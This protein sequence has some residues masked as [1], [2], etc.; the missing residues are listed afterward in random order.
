MRIVSFSDIHGNFKVFEKCR[1]LLLGADIVILSGDITDF[2]NHRDSSRG[3]RELKKIFDKEIFAVT[4]NCDL[5]SAETSLNNLGINISERVI[6]KKGFLFAGIKGSLVTP[7]ST[8]NEFLESDYEK[9]LL[10]IE[11]NLKKEIPFVFVTH[12]PPFDCGCDV[13]ESGVKTGS[14]AIRKFIER[15]SPVVCF[16]GHIHE[17]FGTGKIGDTIIVNP[18]EAN[19]GRVAI[20]DFD[21]G[22]YE[23]YIENF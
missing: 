16:T 3:V 17:A 8:P 14:R 18:G 10:K 1:K 4:G 19:K 7:F 9:M 6:E 15:N 22:K 5:K 12:Q 21:N 13:I 20:M 23:I 2:G 11:K